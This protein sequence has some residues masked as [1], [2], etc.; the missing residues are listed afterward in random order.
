MASNPALLQPLRA[1]EAA[2]HPSFNANIDRQTGYKTRSMLVMPIRSMQSS[3]GQMMLGGKPIGVVQTHPDAPRVMIANSNLVPHWATQEHFDDLA[4]KAET[5]GAH[6][7]L[8]SH[9]R[10]HLADMDAMMAI[11]DRHGLTVKLIFWS[12]SS[13]TETNDSET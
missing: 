1:S 4:A 3:G 10:G 6:F 2:D 8:V 9:M 5:S 11:A 13:T 12:T 7:L